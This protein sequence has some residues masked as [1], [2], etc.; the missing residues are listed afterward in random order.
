MD[1]KV[2]GGDS[3]LKSHVRLIE[4]MKQADV[5]MFLSVHSDDVVLMPPNEPSILGKAE[6]EEWIREYL[7]NF[8]IVDLAPADRHV[9]QLGDCAV[10]RWAYE[11]KIRPLAGG[12]TIRDEGRFLSLWKRDSTGWLIAQS[13]WNSVQPVGAGTR[14]FMSLLKHRKGALLK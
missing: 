12:E 3:L 1:I 5:E 10:E 13:M 7:H 9:T 8:R 14:R 11:V 4:A 2:R 6:A